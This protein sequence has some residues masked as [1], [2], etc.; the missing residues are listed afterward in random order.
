M[1]GYAMVLALVAAGDGQARP[2]RSRRRSSPAPGTT[3]HIRPG[4]GAENASPKLSGVAGGSIATLAHP[5]WSLIAGF[6][7]L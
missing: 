1:M 7:P 5:S 2:L 6:E 4:A 3:G